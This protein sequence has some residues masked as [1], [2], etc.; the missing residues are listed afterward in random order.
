[1]PLKVVLG[2]YR[3]AFKRR[4]TGIRTCTQILTFGDVICAPG[5]A[6][7]LQKDELEVSQGMSD[8]YKTIQTICY[9]DSAQF[10]TFQANIHTQSKTNTLLQHA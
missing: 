7:Y 2:H 4:W 9:F 3:S 5:T 10:S 6:R 1:M 8:A